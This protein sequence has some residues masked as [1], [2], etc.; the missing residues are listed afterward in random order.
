[1]IRRISALLSVPAGVEWVVG[2]DGRAAAPG[3]M[4]LFMVTK[5]FFSVFLWAPAEP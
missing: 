4:M 3:I 5:G 2:L 1:M